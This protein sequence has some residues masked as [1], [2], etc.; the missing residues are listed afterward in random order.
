M[1]GLN[2]TN[3]TNSIKKTFEEKI[4]ESIRDTSLYAIIK[5][6]DAILEIVKKEI[7]KALTAEYNVVE[8]DGY[9]TRRVTAPVKEAAREVAEKLAKEQIELIS[10][11][12][13]FVAIIQAMIKE[14]LPTTIMQ[15]LEGMVYNRLH[16]FI[17]TSHNNVE[18]DIRMKLQQINIFMPQ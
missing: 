17:A 6:E 8:K 4:V 3:E 9:G 14:A 13:Q 12:G 2:M 7:T 18:A 16:S 15:V 1:E 5:D 11:N 10:N